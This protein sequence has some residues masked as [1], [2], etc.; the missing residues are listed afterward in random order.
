VITE[1]RL[2]GKVGFLNLSSYKINFKLSYPIKHV[3]SAMNLTIL[4]LFFGLVRYA[5]AVTHPTILF[6]PIEH[7]RSAMNPT[8]LHQMHLNGWW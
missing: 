5:G 7:V 2:F 8:I 1:I 4:Y 3:R 6:Y